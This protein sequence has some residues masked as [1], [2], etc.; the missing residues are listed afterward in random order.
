MKKILFVLFF[1]SIHSVKA[2]INFLQP[3]EMTLTSELVFEAPQN[4]IEE[5]KLSFEVQKWPVEILKYTLFR[6]QQNPYLVTPF[7][8][9]LS[10]E[11]PNGTKRILIPVPVNE[12]YL[13][14]FKSEEGFNENY[15]AF[16]SDTYQW[17]LS[18]L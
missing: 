16:L 1:L 4:E 15:I 3:Y 10:I 7:Y 17:L 14:A 18:R 5:I 6:I 2:Q 9:N 8:I 11:H 12:R 13:K